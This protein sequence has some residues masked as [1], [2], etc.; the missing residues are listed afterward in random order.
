[1]RYFLICNFL[2]VIYIANA[3]SR[4]LQIADSLYHEK[5]FF[6]SSVWYERCIYESESNTNIFAAIYGKINCLKSLEKYNDVIEFT[7]F[8][9]N[10]DFP[11]SFK[12]IM[13]YQQIFCSYLSGKFENSISLS[14]QYKKFFSDK[15]TL[16]KIELL[17]VLSLNQLLK[18]HEAD[19][20][21]KEFIVQNKLESKLVENLYFNSPHLKSVKKATNL[22]TF[23]PGAGLFYCGKYFEGSVNALLQIG[24]LALGVHAFINQYYFASWFV[25]AGLFASFHNGGIR[26][27]ETLVNQYN[28][29]KIN[30]FNE[31]LKDSLIHFFSTID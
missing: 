23:I 8:Y 22:S 9:I 14:T 10:M 31:Q 20:V 29:N 27:S 16:L 15:K 24:F 26:R 18:W 21:L 25:G 2:F 3:Q 4:S 30:H 13:I 11:D 17:K 5:K 6:E 12:R 28:Q 7:S 19:S 1:M